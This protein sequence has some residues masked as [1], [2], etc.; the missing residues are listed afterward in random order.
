MLSAGPSLRVP[1]KGILT[2]IDFGA[3]PEGNVLDRVER[4]LIL[5]A[6]RECN[7]VVGGTRGAAALLGLN[8]T[9]LAYKI[10]K[11]RISRSA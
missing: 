2:A 1:L 6:L 9:G 5:R 4:Q 8:R 3:A 11:F 10:R 7:W